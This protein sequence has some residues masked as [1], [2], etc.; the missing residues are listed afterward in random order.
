MADSPATADPLLR[1][2]AICTGRYSALVEHQWLVDG[3]ASEGSAGV[4]DSLWTLA[5][6][7]AGPAEAAAAMGWR[8]DA[9]VA[10]RGL[11]DRAY[12]ARDAAAEKRSAQLLQACADLIGQS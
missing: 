6:A 8:I 4:R 7:V 9:K 5:E 12:F 2:F 10:Q 11:L 1:Q 3:P